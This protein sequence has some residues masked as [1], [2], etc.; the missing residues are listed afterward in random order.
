MLDPR[1]RVAVGSKGRYMAGG[2]KARLVTFHWCQLKVTVGDAAVTAAHYQTCS[3]WLL[4][5]RLK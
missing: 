5:R 3:H 4:F 1:P 2:S